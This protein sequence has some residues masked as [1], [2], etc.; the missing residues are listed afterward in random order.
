M[1]D[2]D[3]SDSDCSPK[4]STQREI[5]DNYTQKNRKQTSGF[6]LSISEDTT[7]PNKDDSLTLSNDF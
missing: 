2:D 5:T 4:G 6:G 1:M 7:T 3:F